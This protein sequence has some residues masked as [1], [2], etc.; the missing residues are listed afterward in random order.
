MSCDK[1]VIDF[2]VQAA[3]TG[4]SAKTVREFLEKH[5]SDESVKTKEDTIT[6]AIRALLEVRYMKIKNWSFVYCRQFNL[7]VRAWSQQ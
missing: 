5:Y 3:A 2:L 4:R 1:H 6:L 7:E